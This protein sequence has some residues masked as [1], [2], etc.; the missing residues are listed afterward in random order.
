VPKA[1][2]LIVEDEPL[3]ERLGLPAVL[4]TAQ[5]DRTTRERASK[6]GLSVTGQTSSTPATDHRD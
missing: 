1:K 2:V 6:K 3:R 4:V 5:G